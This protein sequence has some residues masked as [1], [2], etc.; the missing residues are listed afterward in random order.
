VLLR[1]ALLQLRNDTLAEDVVRMHLS[2]CWKSGALRWPVI[3]AHLRYQH[4]EA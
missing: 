2:Q 3:A 4:Y 1:F